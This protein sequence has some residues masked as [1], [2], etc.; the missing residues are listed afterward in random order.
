[1]GLFRQ[2]NDKHFED[3]LQNKPLKGDRKN[4]TGLIVVP[5]GDHIARIRDFI[6]D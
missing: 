2:F 6:Y 3:V 1:M 4:T 5:K